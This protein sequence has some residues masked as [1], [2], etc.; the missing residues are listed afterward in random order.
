MNKSVN[1]SSFIDI[2]FQISVG[3][4]FFGVL[5]KIGILIDLCV[6]S[7]E[8]PDTYTRHIMRAP[9]F[10]LRFG[11]ALQTSHHTLL[12]V[13]F[14]AGY[15]QGSL[16]PPAVLLAQKCQSPT[17]GHEP[18]ERDQCFRSSGSEAQYICRHQPNMRNASMERFQATH[19]YI[20]QKFPEGW[21]LERCLRLSAD[22]HRSPENEHMHIS[23]GSPSAQA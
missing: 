15:R 5:K 14:S 8:G 16:Q 2:S 11:K 17:I 3:F 4:Y 9:F 21:A 23:S 19:V 18:R 22:G 20:L 12:S 7:V 10:S 13:G 1:F 6:S